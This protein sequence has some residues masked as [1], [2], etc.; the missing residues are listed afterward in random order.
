MA[1]ICNWAV[2]NM[3][4]LVSD[5]GVILI[6][7]SC[8]AINQISPESGTQGNPGYVPAQYGPQKAFY[9]GQ[10]RFEAPDPSSPGF[11]PYDQLTQ[12]IVLGWVFSD[13]G[14]KKA[15]IEADRT[16]KVQKQ[17]TP[18]VAQGLPW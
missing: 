3:E 8:T 14:D 7:W 5:G 13:L 2:N 10:T 4:R 11:V 17:L 12:N 1:I 9:A 18:V 16:A 15:E 6:D